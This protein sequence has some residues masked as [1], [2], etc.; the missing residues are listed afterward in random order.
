LFEWP[1][2]AP[3]DKALADSA[4]QAHFWL[5]WTIGAVL[6]LHLAAVIWHRYVKRDGVLARMWS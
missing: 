1:S 2:L 4:A 6:A 5:A 3:Q